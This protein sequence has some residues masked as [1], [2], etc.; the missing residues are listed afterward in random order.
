[1]AEFWSELT[2]KAGSLAGKW[3]VYAAFGS[4]LLYLLGYLTLH[5][6]LSAYGVTGG[7]DILDQRYLFAGSRFLVFFAAS[8]PSVLIIVLLLVA[9][10]YG[11]YKL[12]PTPVKNRLARWI[13]DWSAPATRLPLLGIVVGV[14]LIQLVLR[15]CFLFANLLVSKGLPDD[16]LS[17]ILLTS[18][19]NIALYF[20]GLVA[21][22]LISG[23]ILFYAVR[24]GGEKGSAS[25][26]LVG[27]LAFLVTAEFLLL[28]VNYGV[29]IATQQLPRVAEVSGEKLPEGT[30]IWLVSDTKDE[31][32][33]FVRDPNDQR[34]L[35]TVPRKENK[36]KIVGYDDIFCELFSA[37][38]AG[39]RPCSR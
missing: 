33:Y 27:V 10:S 5:G 19:T 39:P 13:S 3:T 2:E 12:I 4:F 18:D 36:T 24:R 31:L 38:H 34:M 8:V 35:L 7:L 21:G 15:K 29:L 17:Y 20:M 26:F 22:T 11:P 37:K 25:E 6:Q 14:G 1:M 28:P 9:I 30:R 16:W 23:A 32:T